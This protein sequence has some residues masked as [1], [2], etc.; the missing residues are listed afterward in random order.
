MNILACLLYMCV[1]TYIISFFGESNLKVSYR[2]HNTSSPNKSVFSE[3][4]GILFVGY[5]TIITPKK[6]MNYFLILFTICPLFI[7]SFVCVDAVCLASLCYPLR[8]GNVFY[9]FF[10]SHLLP[11]PYPWSIYLHILY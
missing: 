6:I 8:T 7:Y 3:N 11:V 1:F 5:N 2:H 9:S 4:K 10:L